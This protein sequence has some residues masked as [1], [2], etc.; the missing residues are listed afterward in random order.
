MRGTVID[1][2][3]KYKYEIKPEI[4]DTRKFKASEKRYDA[5]CKMKLK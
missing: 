4:V 2:D 3:N 5:R 1:P